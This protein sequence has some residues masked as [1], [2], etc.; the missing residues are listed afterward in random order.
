MGQDRLCGGNRMLRSP[1]L[2]VRSSGTYSVS[3]LY[4]STK[5]SHVG[6]ARDVDRVREGCESKPE[7][8]AAACSSGGGIATLAAAAAVAELADARRSGRRGGNPVEVRVLSAALGPVATL[9][10]GPRRYRLGD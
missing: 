8:V 10:T 4:C 1:C 2:R 6:L 3:S 5:H 9:A 7:T